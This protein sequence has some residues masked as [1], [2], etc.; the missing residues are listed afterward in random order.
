[1]A[2]RL[3]AVAGAA[4]ALTAGLTLV[5]TPAEAHVRVRSDSTASGSYGALTFRV[6]NE[7]ATAGTTKL[8][9]ELPQDTPFRSVSV[10]PV[11]GWDVT[12]TEEPLPEPVES[13]GAT[14]TRAVRTVTWTATKGSEIAVGQYQEFSLSVGP[15]PAPGVVPLPAV[16]SYAD[17]EVVRWDQPAPA[18]GGEPEHPVP[19]LEITAA[20]ASDHDGAP[21]PAATVAAA[22]QPDRTARAL[23]GSAL[24][25]AVAGLVV[26]VL[27]RRRSS[28]PGMSGPGM[29][30]PGVSG[31]GMSGPA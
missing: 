5:D 16:Q 11:P 17:G 23:G 14:L 19:V 20:G 12:T 28:G 27:A 24:A 7:S 1:V 6:P 22:G 21:A 3:L 18:S 2:V 26:A 31:P 9:V 4:L 8:A 13:D 25:V 15:L 29:S 30:G 10:K